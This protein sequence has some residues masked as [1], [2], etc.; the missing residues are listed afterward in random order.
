MR[1]VVRIELKEDEAEVVTLPVGRF[2]LTFADRIGLL[3]R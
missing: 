2:W 3:Y 1:W